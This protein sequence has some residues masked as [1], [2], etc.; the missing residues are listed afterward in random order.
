MREKPDALEDV[1]QVLGTYAREPDPGGDIAWMD[2]DLSPQQVSTTVGE[3][4]PRFTFMLT[5]SFPHRLW[6]S[7]RS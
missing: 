7:W 2:Q 6:P 1:A 3:C 4:A 5:E